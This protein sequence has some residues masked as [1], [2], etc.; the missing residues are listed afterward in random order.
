MHLFLLGNTPGLE[1]VKEDFLALC[2]EK[3]R[4]AVLCAGEK[5]PRYAPHYLQVLT[6]AGAAEV[7]FIGEENGQLNPRK[8]HAILQGA[9]GIV[10]GGGDTY[11]YQQHYVLSTLSDLIRQKVRAGVPYLGISAGAILSC[12]TCLI[13]EEDRTSPE[14]PHYLPG[15][16]FMS[17]LVFPHFSEWDGFAELQAAAAELH[18]QEV[19]G[20]DEQAAAYFHDG[21]LHHTYG[22]WVWKVKP[23]GEA[24]KIMKDAPVLLD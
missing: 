13:P 19:W 22:E 17:T 11:L 1:R 6:T 14:Q 9:S 10:V 4:I 15:F 2:G 5:W 16:G 3:P 12:L 7:Q 20:L 24:Q 18:M 23:T 8:A 21:T